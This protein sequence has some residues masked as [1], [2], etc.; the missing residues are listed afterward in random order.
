MEFPLD[1]LANR[2]LLK[3]SEEEGDF[4]TKSLQGFLESHVTKLLDVKREEKPEA[5]SGHR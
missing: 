4:D 1:V 3:V 5:L 2:E